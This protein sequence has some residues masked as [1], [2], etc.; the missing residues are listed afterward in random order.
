MVAN[1][2]SSDF[3]HTLEEYQHI[4]DICFSPIDRTMATAATDGRIRVCHILYSEK[5]GID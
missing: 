2:F 4:E 1:K 3:R 5:D